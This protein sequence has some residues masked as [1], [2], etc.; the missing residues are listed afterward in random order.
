[1]LTIDADAH[2]IECDQTWDYLDVADAAYR[3]MQI[4]P[5]GS[6]RQHWFLDGK[7]R[8]VGGRLLSSTR[9]AELSQSTGRELRLQASARDLHDVRERLEHMSQLAIDIQVLLP[10]FFIEQ[11]SPRADIERALC[12]AYNRWLAHLWQCGQGRLRWVVVPPL[13]SMSNAISALR[14]A[15]ENGACGVFLRPIEGNRLLCDPYFFPLYEEASSLDLAIVIH[16]GNA[17]PVSCDLMGQYNGRGSS[18]CKYKLPLLSAFVSLVT[19]GVPRLFP[20][21]R[22]AFLEAGAQWL[23]YVLHELRHRVAQEDLADLLQCNRFY[24]ACEADDD[25]VSITRL[26]GEDNIVIGTDYGHID[27]S[28]DLNAFRKLCSRQD[29]HRDLIDK[30]ISSNPRALYGL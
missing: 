4:G 11:V 27:P 12:T 23:P 17:S 21:L 29:L 10:T 19:A 2:V 9:L 26:V 16:I 24:V 13:L 20:D 30:I 6:E 15:K 5:P 14:E 22:W 25:L 8:G 1:M 18:Y 28:S 7:I 3:P